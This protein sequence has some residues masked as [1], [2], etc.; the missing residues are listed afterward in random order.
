MF[1]QQHYVEIAKILRKGRTS[2]IGNFIELF[3]KDSK[4]F[5]KQKFINAIYEKEE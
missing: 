1:T 3:E 5:D 2:I 4:K